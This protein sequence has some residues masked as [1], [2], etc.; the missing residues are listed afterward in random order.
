MIRIACLSLL[1]S[2]T[3]L[4]ADA[5]LCDRFAKAFAKAGK[6][7]GNPPDAETVGFFRKSCAAKPDA[8]VKQDADCFEKVKTQADLGQ[9]MSK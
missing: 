3:A 5:K 4:A 2:S 6:A 7:V 1:L 9:C 8:E